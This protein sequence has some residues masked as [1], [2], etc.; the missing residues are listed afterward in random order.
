MTTRLR[1]GYSRAL[2]L[3]LATNQVL[4]EVNGEAFFCAQ[5]GPSIHNQELVDLPLGLELGGELR[6]CNLHTLLVE[7]GS[8]TWSHL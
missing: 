1:S 7:H 5:I 3:L 2:T 6:S 4:Q 8:T